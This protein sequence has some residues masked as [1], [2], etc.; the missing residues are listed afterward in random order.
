MVPW[1]LELPGNECI[2]SGDLTKKSKQNKTTHIFQL[3]LIPALSKHTTFL[4]KTQLFELEVESSLCGIAYTLLLHAR[5]L[6]K[7]QKL[8]QKEHV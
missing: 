3:F 6:L 8:C 1:V 5:A 4:S 2:V 7:A